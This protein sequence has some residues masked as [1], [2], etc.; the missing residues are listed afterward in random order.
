MEEAARVVVE[1]RDG[2]MLGVSRG[3]RAGGSEFGSGR[4]VEPTPAPMGVADVVVSMPV[5][6][7]ALPAAD[8]WFLTAER[9]RRARKRNKRGRVMRGARRMV[10]RVVVAG[11]VVSADGGAVVCE[12]PQV[13]GVREMVRGREGSEEM[14][15]EREE[16]TDGGE[17]PGREVTP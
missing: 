9:S 12:V 3:G 8:A 17:E 7:D 4:V 14:N 6:P 5:V 13:V 10:G 2:V 16:G 15:K 11:G 1:V